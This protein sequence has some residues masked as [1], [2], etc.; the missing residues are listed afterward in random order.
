MVLNNDYSDFLSAPQA[1][2]DSTTAH[3]FNHSIQF[4]IGGL[5]GTTN[6]ALPEDVFVEG[7]ATWME[8]EVQDGADDNYHYLWPDFGESMG[9]YGD[10]FPYPYWITFR[11][12]TERYGTGSAGGSEQ[13]MQQFW[14]LSSQN[15]ANNQ[16]AM[17]AALATRGTTLGDAFHA[18]AVAVKF[19]RTCGGGYVYPYCFEEGP[20]YVAAAGSPP[21]NRTIA[22]VGGNT[23]FSVD[24]NYALAWVALP[25]SS[26]EYDVTLTNNSG[27]GQLRGTVACDTGSGLVLSPLPAVAAGGQSRTLA[28]FDP[29]G[30]TSRV[31]VVTNQLQTSANPNNSNSRSFSVST[32]A[33]SSGMQTLSVTSP[34][35]SGGTGTVTSSPTGI[36][37]GDDCTE[38]YVS[39][40]E[41]TLTATPDAGSTFA[42]WGVDCSGTGTCTVTMSASHQVTAAF[43]P[44]VDEIAP[45]TTIT[46]GPTGQTSD[47]TPT[48]SF[49]SN[50]AGSTFTCQIDAGTLFGCA[51]PYT[52]TPALADGPHT[53]SV[54]ARD[55]AGNADPTPDTR[56]FTV[57]GGSTDTD[58]PET[59]ITGGPTGTTDDN[60]PTFTFG[61]DEANSTFVCQLDQGLALPCDSPH[62][63]ETLAS[64]NHLFSVYARDSAGN[65]DPTPA[66]RDFTVAAGAGGGPGDDFIAPVISRMRLSPTRFRAARSGAPLA[67]AVGTRLSLRLSE[68]AMVTFRVNKLAPG[69]RVSGRCVRPTARNRRAPRC[70][71][72]VRLRGRIVR[73]LAAGTTALRYRGRLAG[74]RLRPGPYV[75]TA[76]A[77]DGVGN[78]SAV[79]RV[80]FKIVR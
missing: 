42:G 59:T 62:T 19:N 6:S 10:P 30:C 57:A 13:V 34:I 21:V 76:Q 64:G 5:T 31:L 53:F 73:Q 48:F 80:G 67:A 27:G 1:S 18:Y 68:A 12:L 3:E 22:S 75:L 14:E 69:R 28:G 66:T 77:R 46:G 79:R 44:L 55:T 71:R 16:S 65:A 32:D 15:T 39:G 49:T 26:S 25:S 72:T 78:R 29:V 45:Q 36:D 9:A 56:S 41:V 47:S 8:D 51:S 54:Y 20:G 43:N 33:S 58:P 17:A 52:T 70:T 74:R 2:L 63:T 50:E 60:T 61:S 40:T 37:C 7:G 35:G 24:D 4:G 11:G 23:T 38:S